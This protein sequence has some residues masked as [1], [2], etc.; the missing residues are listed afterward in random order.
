MKWL[1]RE[2]PHDPRLSAALR[3]L[4]RGSRREG[5]ELRQ[6][7]L[8]AAMP[9]LSAMRSSQARWWEWISRWMPVAVPLGL[10]ASLLAGLILPETEEIT[11]TSSYSAELVADS[12]LLAAAYSEGSGASQLAAHLV[13]PGEAD[14]LLEE[15]VTQ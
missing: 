2:P 12:T 1:F 11:P 13:A 5:A 14:W 8:T 15:A 4:E 7:I 6:R 10:A 3:Q 9:Q